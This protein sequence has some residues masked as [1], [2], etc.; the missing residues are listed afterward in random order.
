MSSTRSLEKLA[1]FRQ[2]SEDKAGT[3]LQEASRAAAEAA[4]ALDAAIQD[5]DKITGWKAAI[6]ASSHL[7]LGL[8][9]QSLELELQA[10]DV[11]VEEDRAHR[12]ATQA[13]QTA[14]AAYLSASNEVSVVERRA[15][16]RMEEE[17]ISRE[18]KSAD[19]VSDLWLLRRLN[20][21]L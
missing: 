15:E 9:E 5:R 6:G 13:R 18:R 10:S 11:I 19:L 17:S 1:R 8:Y 4:Q 2:I 3:A 7:A 20:E 14:M 12:D 21:H 16:R